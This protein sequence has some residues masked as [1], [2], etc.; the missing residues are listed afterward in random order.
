MK[1]FIDAYLYSNLGDD[2]FVDILLQRYPHTRFETISYFYQTLLP[3]IKVH[4]IRLLS[5]MI[6]LEKIKK[7]YIRSCD[8]IVSIGGSM[9][10]EGVSDETEIFDLGKDC[11]VLGSNFG[12][13]TTQRYYKHHEDIFSKMKDVCFREN[14][15]YRLFNHLE[16]VRK[17]PDIVFSLDTKN[18]NIIQSNKVII[19][20]ISCQGDL[21]DYRIYYEKKVSELCAMFVKKGYQVILMSF[22]KIQGDEEAIDRIKQQCEVHVDKYFY[23]GNRKEALNIIADSSIVVGTRFHANILG[24]LLNKTILPISYSQKTTHMLD[25]LGYKGK[26]IDLKNIKDFDVNSLTH[27][28]LSLKIDIQDIKKMSQLQFKELDQVLK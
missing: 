18:I 25:D 16:N 7:Y 27:K 6:S 23:R 1:V 10:I 15:S 8:A 20:V 9:Y 21:R 17:A 12:P 22:C 14:Y 5:K 19:S 11:Y 13:Y 2:L 24:L 4:S 26:I 3:N 28:D